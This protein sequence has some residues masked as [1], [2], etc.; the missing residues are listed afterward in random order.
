V[1]PNSALPLSGSPGVTAGERSWRQP[2]PRS[3]WTPLDNSWD[4]FSPVA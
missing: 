1:R 2:A 3:S 4:I